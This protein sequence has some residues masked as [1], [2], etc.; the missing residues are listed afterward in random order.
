MS[1]CLTEKI[2]TNLYSKFAKEFN[3]IDENKI[4]EHI[5][6][7]LNKGNG[8]FYCFVSIRYEDTVVYTIIKTIKK[9]NN[10]KNINDLIKKKIQNVNTENKNKLFIKIYMVENNKENNFVCK[11]L[12]NEF[13]RLNSELILDKNQ[14]SFLEHIDKNIKYIYSALIAMLMIIYIN[15]LSSLGILINFLSVDTLTI[16]FNTTLLYMLLF[17]C[18]LFIVPSL[19]SSLVILKGESLLDKTSCSIY[20][21]KSNDIINNILRIIL[22]LL[23]VFISSEF[24]NIIWKNSRT[25]ISDELVVKPYLAQTREPALLE[26]KFNNISKDSNNKEI[27]LIG[28]DTK[29][30][31]YLNIDDIK[32]DNTKLKIQNDVCSKNNRNDKGELIYSKALISLLNFKLEEQTLNYISNRRYKIAKISDISFSEKLPDFDETFCK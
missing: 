5:N 10:C 24:Y 29:F 23:I 17:I 22:V 4:I 25:E 19:V 8:I 16:V 6:D 28:K 13:C 27:L 12:K 32:T 31:Y 14:N 11:K 15:K 1:D 20:M 26:V 9:G 30:I 18:I 2:E 3:G 21:M 7:S